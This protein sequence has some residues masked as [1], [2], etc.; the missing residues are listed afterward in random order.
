MLKISIRQQICY[1]TLNSKSF[2]WFW[3]RQQ[4]LYSMNIL[5]K[6]RLQEECNLYW[7][8]SPHWRPRYYKFYRTKGDAC[9]D[10]LPV[11]SFLPSHF[12]VAVS[13]CAVLRCRLSVPW[14]LSCVL[15]LLVCV[16]AEKSLTA[17]FKRCVH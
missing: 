15:S 5:S 2:S 1:K 3:A 8:N 9:W 10:M 13:S 11:S 17:E 14:A 4:A 7:K 12:P 6:I 16:V